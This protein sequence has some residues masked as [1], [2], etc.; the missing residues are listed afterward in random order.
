MTQDPNE[1]TRKHEEALRVC[2]DGCKH[3]STLSAAAT[4]ILVAGY[5][6]AVIGNALLTVA[7][8]GLSLSILASLVSLLVPAKSKINHWEWDL[9][10]AFVSFYFSVLLFAGGALT[11]LVG[12]LGLPNWVELVAGGIVG[13]IL[14]LVIVSLFLSDT[15]KRRR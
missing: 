13:V 3:M 12:S 1:S 2:F 14:T 8:F 4:A 15:V 7:L 6:E 11:A 10:L 5:R 9:A